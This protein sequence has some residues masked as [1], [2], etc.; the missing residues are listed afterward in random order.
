[1][2]YLLTYIFTLIS[3]YLS[4]QDE[5]NRKPSDTVD[6]TYSIY[7]LFSD[8]RLESEN[9]ELK[10]NFESITQSDFDTYKE[11]YRQKSDTI[12]KLI[13]QTE[14][15]FSIRA[16]D[17]IFEFPSIMDRSHY[18]G[19][20]Y[21]QINAQLVK[22]SGAGIC[23]MFLIDQ[24]TAIG[25]SLPAFYDNSCNQPQISKNN[26]FLMTYGT[27]PSGKSCFDWYDQIS[28]I[29]IINISQ[30]KSITDLNTYRYIAI[31]DFSIE[32][33]FWTES[34]YI[35]LKVFD[36]IAFDYS[37]QDHKKKIKYLKGKVEW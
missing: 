36:E 28:T 34:E 10:I 37:G 26:K 31:N 11:K 14:N 15:S 18:Y 19:G 3:L 6:V 13:A 2:K 30:S 5:R 29:S 16:S 7:E 4:A 12:S 1:M 22:V 9:I 32:E 17:T 35:V 20:F 33:I 25:L 27:C 23:E 21:P 8:I 24:E